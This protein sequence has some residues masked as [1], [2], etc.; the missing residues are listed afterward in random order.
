[1]P[2]HF[3]KAMPCNGA[4]IFIDYTHSAFPVWQCQWQELIIQQRFHPQ[5][6]TVP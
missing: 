5:A 3:K 6:L 4:G 1:L 2:D